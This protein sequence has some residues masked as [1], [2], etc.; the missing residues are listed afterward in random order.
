L[1]ADPPLESWADLARE[2][3]RRACRF[4]FAVGGVS[5]NELRA[6][7]RR[8]AL[9]C[10]AELA[11]RLGVPVR[12]PPA[13]DPEL[14]VVTGH[15]PELYHPGVWTKVFLLERLARELGAPG[16]DLVV[17]SDAFDAVELHAP[18]M[19][20]RLGRAREVLAHGGP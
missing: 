7:A 9:A 14:L 8:E 18:C 3:A 19:R 16:L 12:A 1:L 6:E 11:P 2:N 15:Q 17:D 13:E 10:A 20:P 5:A 4:D